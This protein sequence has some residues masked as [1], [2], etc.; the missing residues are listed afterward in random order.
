MED[1]LGDGNVF[2]VERLLMRIVNPSKQP[3][4]KNRMR[5]RHSVMT[6]RKRGRM[7]LNSCGVA[8]DQKEDGDF[9]TINQIY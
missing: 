9:A 3:R 4:S 6:W 8:C 1:I 2:F 5:R 7:K